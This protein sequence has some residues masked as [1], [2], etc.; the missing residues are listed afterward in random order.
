[1]GDAIQDILAEKFA[2]VLGDSVAEYSATFARRAMADLAFSDHNGCYYIVDVKTHRKETHFNMPNL[3]SVERL[4]R[5]YQDDKNYF[6][7]LMVRYS[8]Q[9]TFVRVNKFTLCQSSFWDGIA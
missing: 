2:S 6:V 1:M 9:E 8:I 5:F 3:T 7:I 4:A